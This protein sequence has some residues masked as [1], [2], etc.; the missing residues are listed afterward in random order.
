MINH[1]EDALI[2]LE[3]MGIDFHDA[4]SKMVN[5]IEI[6]ERNKRKIVKNK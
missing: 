5:W 2:R 6:D 4:I 1:D 3:K